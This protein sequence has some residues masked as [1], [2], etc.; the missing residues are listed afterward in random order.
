MDTNTIMLIV[1]G[2]LAL[3]VIIVYNGLVALRTN[4]KE[5]WSDIEVQ[6]KRRYDLI[7]QLI[8]TVQGYVK[9]EKET[10]EAV[11]NA[12]AA[13]MNNS[14]AVES[15]A[16]D[17]NMLSGALKSIFALSESY[18][19]LKANENFAELQRELTDTEDKIQ[20]SRRFY[21]SNVREI[22]IAVQVFPKNLIAKVFHF[23]KMEFFELDESEKAA[24]SKP[25]E[26][27]F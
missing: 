19:D 8:N 3:Y 20:A 2:V 25:V 6:M 10:L 21:N 1:A 22:N 9:H 17:E 24:A 5:S 4:T 14:G 26:V 7:P 13:A 27:K 23:T 18:P 15:Q 12:R 16:Q 11:V